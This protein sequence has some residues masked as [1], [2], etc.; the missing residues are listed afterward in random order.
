MD[1]DV[2]VLRTKI[3]GRRISIEKTK[4][5]TILKLFLSNALERIKIREFIADCISDDL[6][7]KEIFDTLKRKDF[8]KKFVNS[9]KKKQTEKS[10]GYK[11][12]KIFGT[13]YFSYTK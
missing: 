8:V 7:S 11:M 3:P 6:T 10:E 12:H 5:I 4:E 9:F 2:R 13:Y 1:Y